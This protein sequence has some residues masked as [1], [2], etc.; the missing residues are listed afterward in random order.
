MCRAAK[1]VSRVATAA[2][3]KCSYVC[4]SQALYSPG[5]GSGVWADKTCRIRLTAQRDESCELKNESKVEATSLKQNLLGMC[6][7]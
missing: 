5:K 2:L 6:E 3:L 1:T 7:V 4:K